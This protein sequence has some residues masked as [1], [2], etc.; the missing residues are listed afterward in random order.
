MK[1]LRESQ[2]K[3]DSIRDSTQIS[4]SKVRSSDSP[5]LNSMKNPLSIRMNT[6]TTSSFIQ[7]GD[8]PYGGSRNLPVITQYNTEVPSFRSSNATPSLIKGIDKIKESIEKQRILL[9]LNSKIKASR[10]P[11]KTSLLLKPDPY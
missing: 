7:R 3:L 2:L 10:A 5:F 8:D 1:K 11:Y 6:S 9:D 4:L